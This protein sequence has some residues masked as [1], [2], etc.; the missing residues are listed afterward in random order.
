MQQESKQFIFTVLIIHF[1]IDLEEKKKRKENVKQTNKKSNF[2]YITVKCKMPAR[3]F[4]LL[5]V[6]TCGEYFCCL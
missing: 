2:L 6:V 3:Q 5:V 4:I 1:L